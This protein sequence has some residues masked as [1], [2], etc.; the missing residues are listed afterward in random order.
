M[1]VRNSIFFKWLYLKNWK[2]IYKW[3]CTQNRQF[4]RKVIFNA[5]WRCQHIW[6]L[7]FTER[8]IACFIQ[9]MCDITIKLQSFCFPEDVLHTLI[10][11]L[12]VKFKCSLRFIFSLRCCCPMLRCNAFFHPLRWVLGISY[13]ELSS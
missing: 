5:S 3:Y 13:V 11:V 10:E 7:C 12:S 4:R 2:V 9:K 1:H 8:K 6:K